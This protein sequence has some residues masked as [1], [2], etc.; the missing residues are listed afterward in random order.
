MESDAIFAAFAGKQCAGCGGTKST[1]SGFC[2]WCLAELPRAL[3]VALHRKFG[4]DFERAYMASLSW[5]REHPF[6][7][8]H[9]AKQKTLF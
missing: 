7:G 6:Q 8:T 3:R 9:R 4:A 2:R 1:F 5:F